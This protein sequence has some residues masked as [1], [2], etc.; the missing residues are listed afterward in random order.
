MDLTSVTTAEVEALLC[1]L[2]ELEREILEL[3]MQEQQEAEWQGRL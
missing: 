1:L 2:A 3:A